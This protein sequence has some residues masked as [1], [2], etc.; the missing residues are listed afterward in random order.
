MENAL[1]AYFNP[2]LNQRIDEADWTQRLFQHAQE[3]DVHVPGVLVRNEPRARIAAFKGDER[4]AALRQRRA[5][6]GLVRLELWVR[7]ADVARVREFARKLAAEK[8]RPV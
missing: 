8:P 6:L 7:P 1:I 3:V 5:A 4:V 2:T